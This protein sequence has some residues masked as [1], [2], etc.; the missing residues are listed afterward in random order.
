MIYYYVDLHTSYCNDDSFY[1]CHHR[2]TCSIII[3]S[4]PS[5]VVIKT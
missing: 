3:A 5:G 4:L 2:M 1:R